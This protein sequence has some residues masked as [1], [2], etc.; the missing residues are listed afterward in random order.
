MFA[1][2]TNSAKPLKKMALLMSYS[3]STPNFPLGQL[4]QLKATSRRTNLN[5]NWIEILLCRG[6]SL[7]HTSALA[8]FIEV[9]EHDL[10][11]EKINNSSEEDSVSSRKS[12]MESVIS[13]HSSMSSD[14]VNPE[15]VEAVP[16]ATPAGSSGSSSSQEGNNN[17]LPKEISYAELELLKKLEEQNR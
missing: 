5:W 17:S 14:H 4:S 13:S 12:S 7:G 16:A 6:D 10:L 9:V 8:A 11:Q 1:R 3:N 15:A 2:C